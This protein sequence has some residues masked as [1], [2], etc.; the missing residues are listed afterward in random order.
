MRTKI[1]SAN[2]ERFHSER[3]C[4]PCGKPV[5]ILKENHD[6]IEEMAT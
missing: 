5:G 4:A 2:D 1:T 3:F 6:G